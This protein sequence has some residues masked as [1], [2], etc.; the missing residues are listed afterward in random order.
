[1]DCVEVNQWIGDALSEALAHSESGD[2]QSSL[3]AWKSGYTHFEQQ[4]EPALRYHQANPNKVAELEFLIGQIGARTQIDD[5]IAMAATVS[6]FEEKLAELLPI[7]PT[8]E[9][10]VL[11]H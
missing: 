1:M 3:N 2:A 4:I 5:P 9:K 6:L 10:P 7:I 11:T 8:A